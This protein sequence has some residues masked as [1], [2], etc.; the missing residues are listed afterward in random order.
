[1]AED[2]DEQGKQTVYPEKSLNNAPEHIQ[3][4]FQRPEANKQHLSVGSIDNNAAASGGISYDD[5][6]LAQKYPR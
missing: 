4:P 1:M 2:L 5:E 6:K 3:P